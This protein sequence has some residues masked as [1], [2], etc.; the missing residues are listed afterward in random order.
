GERH[1]R[2]DVSPI[3]TRSGAHGRG[4]RQ[5]RWGTID[6]IDPTHDAGPESVVRRKQGGTR[7]VTASAQPGSGLDLPSSLPLVSLCTCPCPVACGPFPCCAEAGAT[8]TG[9]RVPQQARAAAP[10]PNSGRGRR[11]NRRWDGD[12][13]CPP[14]PLPRK[15]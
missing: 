6:K 1:S 13:F 5:G 12:T 3:S 8:P 2:T 7:T 11:A 4:Y 14:P 9:T 10:E 15:S